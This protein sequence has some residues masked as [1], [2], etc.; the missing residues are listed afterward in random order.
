[1]FLPGP[2]NDEVRI[3]LIHEDALLRENHALQQF[4]NTTMNFMAALQVTD[5][6]VAVELHKEIRRQAELLRTGEAWD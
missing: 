2:D 5:R 6:P 3:M 1:M 4:F